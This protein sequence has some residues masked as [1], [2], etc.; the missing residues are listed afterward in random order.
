[1]ILPG[2]FGIQLF[3]IG[4]AVKDGTEV[5]GFNSFRML[6]SFNPKTDFHGFLCKNAHFDVIVGNLNQTEPTARFFLIKYCFKS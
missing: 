6:P 1:M 3:K 5:D 4:I 2:I